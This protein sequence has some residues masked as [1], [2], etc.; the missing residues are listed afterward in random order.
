MTPDLC[1]S[2]RTPVC[3]YAADEG[4]HSF[5]P[6]GPAVHLPPG[7]E[8]CGVCGAER[9]STGTWELRAGQSVFVPDAWARAAWDDARRRA[10]ERG[11]EEPEWE[12]LIAD[13]RSRVP[14][15]ASEE[16]VG[17]DAEAAVKAVREGR[18]ERARAELLEV[19]GRLEY[20]EREQA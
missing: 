12:D 16:Q 3:T 10:A 9:D 5:A 20:Q 13:I 1:P 8:W 11:G 18:K 17:R 14:A 7:E 4:T 6:L 19:Y 2:C 15:D